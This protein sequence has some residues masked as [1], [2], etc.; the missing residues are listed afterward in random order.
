MATITN[1]GLTA[2]AKLANGTDSV[3][4]FTYLA[5]GSG[6]GAEANDSTTL[7]SEISTNGGARAA[8]TCTYESDYKAQWQKTFSFTGNLAINECGVFNDDGDPAGTMLAR[9]KFASTKNVEDGDS[10]QL[11]VIMTVARAA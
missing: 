9:H 1:A 11:T 7:G 4:A 10:L 2:L 6:T 5:L 3:N 8:A